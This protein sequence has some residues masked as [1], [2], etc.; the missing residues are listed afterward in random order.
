MEDATCDD[1]VSARRVEVLQP[2][3]RGFENDFLLWYF[4]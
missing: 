2:G 3:G 1:R 4:P